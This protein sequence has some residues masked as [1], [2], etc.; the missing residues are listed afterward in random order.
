MKHYFGEAMFKI[1]QEQKKMAAS[2][3][4]ANL[5]ILNSLQP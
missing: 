2:R 3:E 1:Q 5:F 4:T